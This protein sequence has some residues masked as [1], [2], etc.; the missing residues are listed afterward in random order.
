M[1]D[2]KGEENKR[3]KKKEKRK[4][5]EKRRKT[6]QFTILLAVTVLDKKSAGVSPLEN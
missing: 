3:E 5:E 2:P 4:K 6:D 1:L